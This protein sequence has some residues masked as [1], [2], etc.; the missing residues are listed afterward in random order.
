MEPESSTWNKLENHTQEK[1][2]NYEFSYSISFSIYS[3][4]LYSFY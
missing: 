2:V 4:S 1:E 3:T